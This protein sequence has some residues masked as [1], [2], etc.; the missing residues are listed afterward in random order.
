MHKYLTGFHTT[1]G[2]VVSEP[3]RTDMENTDRGIEVAA[4]SPAGL[5][6]GRG[7]TDRIRRE[8]TTR[9]GVEAM[10]LTDYICYV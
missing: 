3:V 6:R 7:R 10:I 4:F 9:S 5:T 2:N 1:I 8:C